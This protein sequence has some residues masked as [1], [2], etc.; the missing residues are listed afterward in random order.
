[1][2]EIAA[3][4]NVSSRTLFRLFGSREA[5]LRE[6]DQ[7]PPP[8]ARDRIMEAGLELVGRRGLAG[9]SMEDLA[10]SA[11]VSRATL[12][13][14]I[15]GKSALF[16]E[17]MR[18]YSPWE[19]VADAIDA[20]PDH[21]PEQVMPEVGR[22]LTRAMAGRAGL[23]V[24]IV[25]E[26]VKGDPDTA[27]GVRHAMGRGLPDLVEYLE[28]QMLAGRLRRMDPVLCLQLFA[29]PLLAHMLTRP[30][31]SLFGFR[32]SEDEVVDRVVEGWLRAMAPEPK[33]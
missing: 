24:G 33:R 16:N 15:P 30:L 4:A 32:A 26:M 6:L 1:M 18:T 25:L 3:A 27:E 17:L 23:L 9:F 20:A 12:Y 11:E 8:T 7:E 21:A 13:R 5:L 19:A 10:T 31:A 14:L 28:E 2:A 29:G 22:A